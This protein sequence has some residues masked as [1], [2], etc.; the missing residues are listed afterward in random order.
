MLKLAPP[1]KF[2]DW[3]VPFSANEGTEDRIK[4]ALGRWEFIAEDE[5]T[6]G[7]FWHHFTTPPRDAREHAFGDDRIFGRIFQRPETAGRRAGRMVVRRNR[8]L[9]PDKESGRFIPA[10]L[11]SGY[12]HRYGKRQAGEADSC[13][14][15]LRLSLN[16]LRF[17]RQQPA[18]DQKPMNHSTRAKTRFLERE[19]RSA[20]G[21][22]VALDQEGNWLP[23][24]PGWRAYATP[25]RKR[26]MLQAYLSAVEKRLVKEAEHAAQI[27]QQGELHI[28]RAEYYSISEVEVAWEFASDDPRADVLHLGETLFRHCADDVEARLYRGRLDNVATVGRSLNSVCVV[29]PMARN[30]HLRLYAKTNKR[31][32]FEVVQYALEDQLGALRKE[33]G[34]GALPARRRG[35]MQARPV[36][37]MMAVFGA[38]RERAARHLNEFFRRVAIQEGGGAREKSGL[39]LLAEIAAAVALVEDEAERAR[40][41]RKL[42]SLIAQ[43][44]GYRGNAQRGHL[45]Q[46]VGTLA[47]RGV[48][49][50]WKGKRLYAVAPAYGPAAKSLRA[51]S[52]ETLTALFGEAVSESRWDTRHREPC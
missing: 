45:G 11:C 29:L 51:L 6:L 25:K 39:E 48:L 41:M 43:Q 30:V 38:I 17:I 47:R 32:R 26:A 37:E 42:M 46:A 8:L 1:L 49:E 9:H 12:L 52:A 19:D 24:S 10:P 36:S 34:L 2:F 5:D 22:E 13:V 28:S 4:L 35:A 18:D 20:F 16:L 44:G 21:D 40:L 3:S 14:A 33:A 23:D 50:Y 7:A 27:Q 15:D 31:I